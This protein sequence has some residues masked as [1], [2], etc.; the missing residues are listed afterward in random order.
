MPEIIRNASLWMGGVKIFEAQSAELDLNSNAVVAIGDG[1]GIGATQAPITGQVT[2]KKWQVVG[3]TAGGT[4]LRTAFMQRKYITSN[5]GDAD[6]VLWKA[7]VVVTQLKSSS[8]MTKG[9]QEGDF[10]ALLVGDPQP[11]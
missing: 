2:A 5:Y 1:V 4:K 10:T 8:D 9:T 7:T 3:G 11:I 6:G